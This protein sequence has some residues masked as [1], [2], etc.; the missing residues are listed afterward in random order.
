[1]RSHFRLKSGLDLAKKLVQMHSD[2]P[3]RSTWRFDLNIPLGLRDRAILETFYSTGIRRAELCNL[4]IDD[5]QVNRQSLFVNQGK[6]KKDRYVP[7]G[8]RALVW[9]ARYVESGRDRLLLDEKEQTLF[10][11]NP[12]LSGL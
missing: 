11:T 1:M 4:R 5:I 10:V 3:P 6:G 7:I 9:I 2:R 12:R 8:L